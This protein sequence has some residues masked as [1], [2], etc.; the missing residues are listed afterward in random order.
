MNG[1]VSRAAGPLIHLGT[2]CGSVDEFV[3]RFAP[4]ATETSLVMPTA[5]EVAPG[6]E[7]RFVI[8]LKDRTPVMSGR[9]RVEEVRP[10]AGGASGGRMVMRVRLL[11]M[12]EPSRNIHK[13]LLACKRPELPA[14][15]VASPK[16][17]PPLRIVRAPTLIGASAPPPIGTAPT[18]IGT[19]APA[20]SPPSLPPPP[21]ATGDD[22]EKTMESIKVPEMQ[23]PSAA[24]TLPAN[25]L[26]ELGAADLASFIELTLFE[27]D[28]APEAAPEASA[29]GDAKTPH[30]LLADSGTK[31]APPPSAVLETPPA[32]GQPADA[33]SEPPPAGLRHKLLH[34]A[35]FALCTV[36]GVL[37]G[38]LLRGSPAPAPPVRPAPE[39]VIVAPAPAPAAAPAAAAPPPAAA[40]PAP[41]PKPPPALE[42][43]AP[44]AA[45]M[46]EG[47]CS[48]SVTS[49]PPDAIVTWGGRSLGH[50][51][52]SGVEV[53]CGAATLVLRH[54]R[55]KDV[56]RAVTA[57][58]AH[59]LVVSER[60]HR[61]NGTLQFAS[62]P[63]RA[64]FTVNG[65][66]IGP[67]PRKM[68][69]WRFETVHVEATLAGYL[70]WKKTFYFKDET[71]KLEARLVSAKPEP[72]AKPAAAKAAASRPSAPAPARAPGP[73]PARAP[74]PAPAATRAAAPA[75]AGKGH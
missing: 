47:S 75:R 66:E 31:P 23:A 1:S 72:R 7:G 34:A 25:P 26:S 49:D 10:V 73:A 3:E 54:E 20:L 68:S 69:T 14:P 8:H 36:I 19:V 57:D 51:P 32:Y 2:R 52:L 60:L 53:P 50:A 11:G 29:A 13:Q 62:T 61:P 63:A 48:I 37:A 16:P 64:T 12:D 41:A 18:L 59:A 55:Y 44:A 24:F 17:P 40:V 65:I 74:A 38:A 22:V 39:P 5:S 33:D 45:P 30:V 42:P 70:P 28:G 58:P 35:P 71:M 67:A 21:P 27:A 6:T 43:E 56:S 9:C 46:P 15:T 4:F